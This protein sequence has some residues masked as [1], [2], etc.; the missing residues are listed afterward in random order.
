[1]YYANYLKHLEE[2]RTE[3]CR[4]RGI[5]VKDLA[6]AGIYFVVASLQMNYKGPARYQDALK[7][8]TSVEKLGRSSLVFLQE[9]LRGEE[10]LV[11]S[12][13][14]WVCVGRDFKPQAI[15]GDIRSVFERDAKEAGT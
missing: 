12:H 6:D 4:A 8:A 1:M 5:S 11:E 3:Y 9:V 13:T 7:I 15:P 10:L 2:G 14:T